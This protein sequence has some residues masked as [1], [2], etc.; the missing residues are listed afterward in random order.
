MRYGVGR[1]LGALG[2]VSR[3]VGRVSRATSSRV[4]QRVDDTD[5]DTTGC[6][7][8]RSTSTGYNELAR[9][10]SKT[11]TSFY[12]QSAIDI[13]AEK[14]S[15][16]LTPT[17]MLYSGKSPDGSHVLSSAK[18]LHMEL[19][20]RIAHR[21]KGFRNLPFIIGCNPTILQVHELY[22]RA[23][24]MLSDFPPIT[25]LEAEGRYCKLV[26]QLLDDHKD[27]VTM[28][29][30]GFRE[31][32]KHIQDEAL[33]R[34]FLDTTLTSRL[35]IRM[36]ATHHIALHEDNPDFVGIICTR[37]SPKKI[38]EK[39]VDFAR[40]LCEHQ[41]GSAPRVR[42]NGHVAARFPFIPLPLDYI[43][44]ELL[45]N[46]MRAT[47]ESHLDTPHNVPDLVVTIAN[48]DIDFV[49]RISDRG[50]GIPHSILDKVLDYHFTTAEESNQ[51]PRMSN[52]FGIITNNGPQSGP[53]HGFGFGL[54]TSVAY[55]EYLGGSLTLQ[56]MQGIG[57]DV[58]LRL[59]HIDGKGESFRI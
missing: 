56:S 33:I 19:P 11:V 22:I 32:R 1:A 18:Y 35:G 27:V 8:F 23:Y 55:A 44:P 45:K 21:I 41:Y 28:L 47:M 54:P 6:R 9:E 26:R 2:A 53:M 12:N 34:N 24:H 7:R 31:S 49:I 16:R 13:S 58:Y 46:A 30:E 52:L 38:I 42:I 48:N 17:T 29:A 14:P 39:W 59:R 57:T 40:R 3:G 43:L 51:D 15:V 36:L 25:D 50:G 4:L 37:L 5:T 10:R 20:V